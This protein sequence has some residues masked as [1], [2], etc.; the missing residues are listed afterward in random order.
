MSD[1]KAK[2]GKIRFPLR[3]HIYPDLAGGACSA[4]PDPLTGF[5]GPFV[6]CPEKKKKKS[7]RLWAVQSAA[8]GGSARLD[9]RPTV[10]HLDVDMLLLGETSSIVHAL[11]LRCATLF[12]GINGQTLHAVC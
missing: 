8:A 11:R 2:M 1:F 6:L 12:A 4:C 5:M 7:R 9:G 10:G 3:L